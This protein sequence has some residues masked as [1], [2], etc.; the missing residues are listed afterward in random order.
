MAKINLSLVLASSFRTNVNLPT[1]FTYL[2]YLLCSTLKYD[3]WN[4]LGY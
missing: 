3:R 4:L 2:F 1:Y